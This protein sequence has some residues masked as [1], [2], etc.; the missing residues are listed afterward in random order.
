MKNKRQ[1][2]ILEIIKE[3]GYASTNELAKTLYSSLPTIRRDLISLEKQGYVLRNHGGAILPPSVSTVMP[4]DFRRIDNLAEKQLLCNFAKNFID[5]YQTIFIDDSTTVLP[6]LKYIKEYKNL[7]VITNSVDAVIEL[8]NS[9]IEFYCT[10]GK[11]ILKN[12]FVGRFAEDFISNFNIDICFFSS[13]G[14]GLNG[15]VMD[16][17]ENKG[18]VIKAMLKNSSKKIYLCDKSKINNVAKFNIAGI[19]EI[20]LVI[21]N[22]IKD[23]LNIPKDKIQYVE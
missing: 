22:A 15:N 7:V 2:E 18:G 9:D 23:S 10:G 1:T 11:C 6:L 20:D 19:D 14:F 17:N 13:S 5:D 16:K 12:N 4:I 21:T 8:R 3:K